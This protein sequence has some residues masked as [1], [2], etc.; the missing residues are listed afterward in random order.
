MYILPFG[1]SEGHVELCK[2]RQVTH[3]CHA[4]LMTEIDPEVVELYT[5]LVEQLS[6][7]GILYVHMVEPRL[8]DGEGSDPSK[9]EASWSLEPFRKAFK[10][11]GGPLMDD[12]QSG[13]ELH[14]SG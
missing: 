12:A 6:E 2:H 11:D 14:V 5:Y 10:G 7:V 13:V 9:F 3:V 4:S 1:D 8:A